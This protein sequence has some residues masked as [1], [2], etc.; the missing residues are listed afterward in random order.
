MIMNDSITLSIPL[1]GPFH[2]LVIPLR[3]TKHTLTNLCM[4]CMD[5][6]FDVVDIRY[7]RGLWVVVK[8]KLEVVCKNI[9]ANE[10]TLL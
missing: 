8:F 5:E 6:G 1:Q 10:A 3:P 2:S 9:M 7:V 4:L